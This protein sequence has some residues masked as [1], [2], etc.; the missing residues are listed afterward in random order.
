MGRTW[1][2][3]PSVNSSTRGS[4]PT[5]AILRTRYG[6][7]RLGSLCM[8]GTRRWRNLGITAGATAAVLL[9]AFDLYQWAAAFA[10]DHFHNDFT[11]YFAAARIGL[12]HGWHSIY[13]LGLQ[14]AQ[15]DAMRSHI[16]IAQLARYISPPPVAW[17]ALPFTFAPYEVAYWLWSALLLVALAGTWYLAAPGAGRVR[18]IH[19][20]AALG[21]I[22]VIYGLQLG[23]PG[24]L[25]AL[26]VAASYALLRSGRPFLSGL[27]LGAIVLKP[28]LG[29]LV[30][31]ALLAGGRLR[32]FAGAAVAIGALAQASA[33]NV[34]MDGIAAYQ[35]RLTFAASVAIN[36]E[37]TVAPYIGDL[38]VTRVLQVSIAIWALALV[39][40][41]RKRSPEWLYVPALV[42]GYRGDHR[43]GTAAVDCRRDT[44]SG[45]SLSRGAETSSRRCRASR[46]R[47][48][49]RCRP[50]AGPRAPV[51]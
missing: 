42:G 45:S 2:R 25:V 18:L 5:W 35:Q 37:L 50:R 19:L 27:A 49:A 22:P 44:G 26:S 13:D 48:R 6:N 40:R 33:I 21:W 11:F 43:L 23:Q 31:V 39:Y 30:P 20:A 41:F 29:F 1:T 47:T 7:R 36:R 24:L 4:K 14:Q 51:R 34:G 15:L 46:L 8:N 17:L 32:A 9:A 38:T 28:Q 16:G 3:V 10:S 12:N